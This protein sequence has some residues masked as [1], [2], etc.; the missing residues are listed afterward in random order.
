MI[1]TSNH[2]LSTY[3]V[4]GTMLGIDDTHYFSLES[5]NSLEKNVIPKQKQIQ[6]HKSCCK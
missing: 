4:P 2:L 6:K 3:Y 1:Y 5:I